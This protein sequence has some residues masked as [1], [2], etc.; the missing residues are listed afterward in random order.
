M[1][2]LLLLL[3]ISV[4]P[5]S[6][7]CGCAGFADPAR[8]TALG[9]PTLVPTTDYDRLWDT[10]VDVVD[11]DFQIVREERPRV[12]GDVQTEG[13]LETRPLI[14]ATVLE[15][16]RDDSV[17]GYDRW[18]STLQTIRRRLMVRMA[19]TSGG[20]QVHVTVLKERE[21]LRQPEG[22]TTSAAIFRNDSSQ[23]RFS[24]PIDIQPLEQGWIPLGNDPSLEQRM[25][26]K[27][28]ARMGG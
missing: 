23:R 16:W 13:R 10:I 9:N 6:L 2:K 24:T 20:Y 1:P 27:L 21:H 28:Q 7:M 3:A 8:G 4:W 17:T 18:E 12:V 26:A 14:G 5:L 19:P 15:P 22:A 11:D 25:I